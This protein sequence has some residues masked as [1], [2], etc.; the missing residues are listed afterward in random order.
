VLPNPQELVEETD[1]TKNTI[2]RTGIKYA[3]CTFVQAKFVV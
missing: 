1:K 2:K 3:K